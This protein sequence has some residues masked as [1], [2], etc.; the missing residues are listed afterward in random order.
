VRSFLIVLP[1]KIAGDLRFNVGINLSGQRSDSFPVNG[2]IPLFHLCD[3]DNRRLRRLCRGLGAGASGKEYQHD[4]QHS[5]RC[6]CDVVQSQSGIQ[7]LRRPFFRRCRSAAFKGCL[8]DAKEE[9]RSLCFYWS[10]F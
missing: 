10:K 4:H 7:L 1:K 3:L 6:P 8:P 2:Y 5:G 9:P